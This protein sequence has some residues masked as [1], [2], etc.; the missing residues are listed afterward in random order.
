M[1]N[2][3]GIYIETLDKEQIKE[4]IKQ[5]TNK[6]KND[7]S[8]N[9]NDSISIKRGDISFATIDEQRRP[10]V[11]LSPDRFNHNS[12]I[13]NV[14]PIYSRHFTRPLP[15]HVE[16]LMHIKGNEMPSTIL[17]EQIRIIE[18]C[19]L[20]EYINKVTIEELNDIEKTIR[21]HLETSGS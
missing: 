18:K 11:I 19:Y 14:A 12:T 15:S 2:S 13:V 16:I 8:Q 17:I 4:E 7:I 3:L 6:I 20:H 10:V 1:H 21:D 5:S 9:N